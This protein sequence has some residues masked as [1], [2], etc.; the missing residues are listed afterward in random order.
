MQGSKLYVGNLDYA[1]TDVELKELFSAYGE[2]KEAVV[3]ER[4]GF[5][6]VTMG[7]PEEAEKAKNEMNGKEVNGRVVKVDEA[8]PPREKGNN[9]RRGGFG[10][11]RGKFGGN[12]FGDRD[13]F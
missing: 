8:R 3:I 12:R 7:T 11:K 6:F 5:G 13:R 10:N 2:V 4:K 1:T 9:N